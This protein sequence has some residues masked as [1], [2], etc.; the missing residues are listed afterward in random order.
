MTKKASIEN[1]DDSKRLMILEDSA[2][3]TLIEM[4]IGSIKD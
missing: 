4:C 3:F 1:D 2:V